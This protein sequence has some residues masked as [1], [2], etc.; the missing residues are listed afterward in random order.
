ME[1]LLTTSEE[2]PPQADT[3]ESLNKQLTEYQTERDAAEKEFTRLL[4]IQDDLDRA[5]QATDY[6]EA[7]EA[8]KRR[9][10]CDRIIGDLQNRLIPETCQK[11]DVAKQS[12][13]QEQ[14]DNMLYRRDIAVSEIE[15]HLDEIEQILIHY[16]A[17]NSDIPGHAMRKY[18]PFTK[19]MMTNKLHK[20]FQVRTQGRNPYAQRKDDIT[21]SNY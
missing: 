1:T 10:Q 15:E 8:K 5:G 16:R 6:T 19:V 3:I 14:I 11:M 4:G 20:V 7:D 17:I 18:H 12:E 9:D 21:D 2:A 13:S